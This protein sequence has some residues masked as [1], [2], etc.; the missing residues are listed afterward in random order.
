[1]PPKS[2]DMA[3][4]SLEAGVGGNQ[5]VSQN[6]QLWEKSKVSQAFCMEKRSNLGK[7]KPA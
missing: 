7:P 5:V 3:G 1:M 2:A 4:S 6:G